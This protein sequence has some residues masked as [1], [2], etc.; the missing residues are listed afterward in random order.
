MCLRLTHTAAHEH[1]HIW[2]VLFLKSPGKMHFNLE[3]K[4]SPGPRI[5]FKTQETDPPLLPSF[6]QSSSPYR[7]DAVVPAFSKLLLIGSSGR[8]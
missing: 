3:K 8:D 6:P 7:C 5:L 4:V 1:T 2:E